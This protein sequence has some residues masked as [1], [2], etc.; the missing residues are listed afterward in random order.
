MYDISEVVSTLLYNIDIP[1][2]PCNRK[3]PP[4]ETEPNNTLPPADAVAAEV[5]PTTVVPFW[6]IR[7]P[8][9]EL[10]VTTAKFQVFTIVV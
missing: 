2:C 10:N 6:Y 1:I 7:N 8:I 4:V 5:E 3:D 9:A